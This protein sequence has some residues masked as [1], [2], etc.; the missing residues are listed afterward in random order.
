[1][2]FKT[3][4]KSLNER[5]REAVDEIDGPV[6]VVAG[7][8]TGK[9]QLLS[10]RVANILRKTDTA[11]ETILCLTFTNKA[12][13]NMRE[14]LTKIIG[15][16]ARNVVVKTFHSFSAEIMNQYP[17]E[18]WNGARLT[19]VPESVQLDIIQSIL[20]KLPQDNPLALSFAGKFSSLKPTKDGLKLAKEAGLTPDKLRALIHANLAYIDLIEAQLIETLSG[21]L[22]AKKLP[23]LLEA[24]E[25]LPAQKVVRQAT[26]LTPLNEV[27]VTSLRETMQKDEGTGKATHTSKWK[28]K[29]LKTIDGE[30]QM[31]DERK[32]NN[33]WLALA[34]VY[35][36]YRETLHHRGFYDYSDMLVEVIT[37]LE[38]NESLR[39]DIQERFLYVL[40]DEFQDTNPAQMRLAH[41]VSDHETAEGKPNIMIVG[42]DDQSIFKFNGAELNNMLNFR[43]DYKV[44][45]P[46]ILEENYRSSQAVLTAAE[47]IISQAEDRLVNREKD[48]S[49]QLLAVNE[50]EEQGTLLHARYET[51]EHEIS[52]VAETISALREK[53]V[54][55]IAV[56][57]RSHDSLQRLAHILLQK[58]IPI[59]YERQRNILEHE[60]TKQILLLTRLIVALQTGEKDEANYLIATLVRHPA[61]GFEAKQLWQLAIENRYQADWFMSL[62]ISKDDRLGALGKWLQWL[63]QHA[64]SQP[65]SVTLEHLIGLREGEEF[66]SPLRN[67]FVEDKELSQEYLEALSAIQTL[68]HMANEFARHGAATLQDF[69]RLLGV[70]EDNQQVISDESPFI[71]GVDAVHL[72]TVHKA[73]GLEYDT[74]FIIDAIESNWQPKQAGRKPPAN[75]PLQPYGDTF[76]DYVRLLYV[77]ATRAKRNLYVTS[78]RLDHSGAD[79]LPTP[80]IHGVFE[81]K[82]CT[83]DETKLIDILEQHV[84]WPSLSS[85]DETVLLRPIMDTFNLSPT[86]LIQ[87]LDV[88]SGG[89]QAFK[90]NGI[91]RLPSVKSLYQFYGTA[92]HNTLEEVQ[93]VINKGEIGLSRIH[94]IYEKELQAQLLSE[95][96]F[97]TYFAKGK[98]ALTTLFEKYNYTLPRGSKPEQKL[99]DIIVN[100]ARLSGKLDRIDFDTTTLTVV[101]YKTGGAL[102]SLETKSASLAVKAWKHKLQLIFYALLVQESPQFKK[103]SHIEAQMVYVEADSA[104]KL[105]LSYEPTKDDTEHLRALVG[106]C[107][108]H[109]Q[110]LDFPDTSGYEANIDGIKSFEKDLLDGTI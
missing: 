65:L 47:K 87:F 80:L 96:D 91:L 77:A 99:S 73:K 31:H 82:H 32:R 9:T 17:D 90:E 50:P 19:T 26:L 67:Y 68:R 8:G 110:N 42:D 105:T 53:G 38:Q 37:Q 3:V 103:Y 2:D 48:I 40:I 97:D 15:S 69:V 44:D 20:K 86:A 85:T 94:T 16:D 79:V 29:W 100:E 78:Y 23:E 81:E 24:I 70:N 72:L 108:K 22:S 60:A 61:W 25:D 35:E 28:A 101:D 63:V 54:T 36:Q 95:K 49:K 11:P 18:F 98:D 107:W 55:D 4:Y 39:A 89:P 83:L 104:K 92:M 84:T 41:L 6:M 21:T 59:S 62:H 33:W 14:R 52:D 10:V 43:H 71:S 109:I 51:V 45:K 76:D 27:L 102:A 7:P 88:P 106:I 30:K 5:Q 56:L 58:D 75:L 12:A 57:A 34:D 74:V 64:D 1:M 66:L 93:K 46:I 13:A